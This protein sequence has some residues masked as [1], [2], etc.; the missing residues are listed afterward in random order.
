MG[1]RW[2]HWCP[3]RQNLDNGSGDIVKRIHDQIM[4]VGIGVFYD[5]QPGV[6]LHE[7]FSYRCEFFL[8]PCKNL[9]LGEK[10]FFLGRDPWH[11]G[12]RKLFCLGLLLQPAGEC[13]RRNPQPVPFKQGVD[14]DFLLHSSA[15]VD[16]ENFITVLVQR[17]FGHDDSCC[18]TA[19]AWFV[20]TTGGYL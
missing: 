3:L 10:V 5:T 19:I 18:K 11:S 7:V 8:Q 4:P 1:N 17:A 14:H 20:G 9:G 16:V 15:L 2:S 12:R 6:N 13:G